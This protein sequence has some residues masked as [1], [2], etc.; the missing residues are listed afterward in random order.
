MSIEHRHLLFD[1]PETKDM[2]CFVF[3]CLRGVL[4]N[5]LMHLKSFDKRKEKRKRGK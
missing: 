4:K 1:I 5:S 3:S 2:L